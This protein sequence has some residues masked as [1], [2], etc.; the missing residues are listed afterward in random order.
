ME[1]SELSE[2]LSK[3]SWFLEQAPDAAIRKSWNPPSENCVG[4]K[5]I[6]IGDRFAIQ[7]YRGGGAVPVHSHDFYELLYV[8]NGSLTMYAGA[9][10]LPL[11]SMEAVMIPDGV[12][13]HLVAETEDTVAI[14]LVLTKKLMNGALWTPLRELPGIAGFLN[15]RNQRKEPAGQIPILPFFAEEADLASSAMERLLC[16]HLQP[17]QRTFLV[18]EPLL[19]LLLTGLDR[20][21]E[22]TVSSFRHSNISE[23]IDDVLRYINVNYATATLQSTAS[24]FGF[25][26]NYLSQMLKKATGSGFRELRQQACIEQSGLLL[27]NTDLSVSEICNQIGFRNVS[28]FYQLFERWYGVTPAMYRKNQVPNEL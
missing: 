12:Q 17:D 3:E 26:P 20:R 21:C 10:Q 16:E 22:G 14:I 2:V 8:T 7:V 15:S 24:R 9:H 11:K 28:H 23:I 1:L 27:A 5:R 25:S 13:H 19:V 18:M 6:G 4:D